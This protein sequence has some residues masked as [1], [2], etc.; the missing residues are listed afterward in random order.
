MTY[1]QNQQAR[2]KGTE[3]FWSK[4]GGQRPIQ[5]RADNLSDTDPL[6]IFWKERAKNRTDL[7][8]CVGIEK[9][10]RTTFRH[11]TNPVAHPAD[12]R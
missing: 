3:K 1:L 10:D 2:M 4:Q 11:I 9:N 5:L 8:C 7:R 12:S 6:S